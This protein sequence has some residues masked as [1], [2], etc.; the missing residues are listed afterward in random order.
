MLL[1]CVGGEGRNLLPEGCSSRGKHLESTARRNRAVLP[2][3]DPKNTQ[4]RNYRRDEKNPMGISWAL[5]DPHISWSTDVFQLLFWVQH[6]TWTESGQGIRGLWSP[7]AVMTSS[8][9]WRIKV[10]SWELAF[11][12]FS[13]LPFLSKS[14]TTYFPFSFPTWLCLPVCKSLFPI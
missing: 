6:L 10:I 14:Y 12:C 5:D 7:G 8:L 13:M 4:Y 1:G 3:W 2:L 11:Q 9:C